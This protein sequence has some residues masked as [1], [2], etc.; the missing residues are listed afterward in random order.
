MKFVLLFGPPGSGKS[1]FIQFV[2]SLGYKAFDLEKMGTSTQTRVEAAAE[3]RKALEHEEGM[4]FLGMADVHP[5]IFPESSV[6]I[7][8]LPSFDVYVKRV[9]QRDLEFPEKRFQSAL[10]KHGQFQK[11]AKNFSCVIQNDGDVHETLE[12]ILHCLAKL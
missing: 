5:E 4:V 1:T 6:K 8:M 2:K 10:E 9:E 11:Q 12:Q 7:L 3:L